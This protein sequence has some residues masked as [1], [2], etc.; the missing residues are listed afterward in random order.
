MERDRGFLIISHPATGSNRILAFAIYVVLL[1]SGL[2]TVRAQ[3]VHQGSTPLR[4][5][6]K[7]M[8]YQT[9]SSQIDYAPDS[10]K[11]PQQPWI[12]LSDREANTTYTDSAK[13][14]IQRSLKYLEQLYVVEE[15]GAYVHIVRDS[16]HVGLLLSKTYE[17]CGWIHKQNLLLWDFCI[18]DRET[19]TPKRVM[20]LNTLAHI[21]GNGTHSSDLVEFRRSPDSDTALARTTS[22]FFQ[23]FFLL[24]S[25]AG[26]ALVS[27][28]EYI[29]GRSSSVKIDTLVAGWIPWTRLVGWYNRVAVEPNWDSAACAERAR[30]KRARVFVNEQ[31]ALQ[32]KN[33]EEAP[34]EAV[35]WDDDPLERRPPGEWRRF[36]VLRASTTSPGVIEVMA[37]GS[38]STTQGIAVRGFL[39]YRVRNQKHPLFRR[40]ILLSRNELYDH[41]N[42]LQELVDA[43]AGRKSLVDAWLKL[44][45][46]SDSAGARRDL[47][48]RSLAAVNERIF[49]MSGGDS[50]SARTRLADIPDTNLTREPDLVRYLDVLSQKTLAL[51]RAADAEEGSYRYMFRSNGVAYYWIGEELLP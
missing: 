30:G 22:Q 48:D 15:K 50:F 5:L 45:R 49:G 24:K 35:W 25:E 13:T 14:E 38:T 31:A 7:P 43:R 11:V 4:I 12:V 6:E 34:D 27:T 8:K 46:G 26:W 10:V 39:T 17:D 41:V 32:Y 3:S 37:T 1:S 36:P 40:V 23:F 51:K 21:R 47:L 29:G 20:I 42:K 16:A 19:G 9:P 2:S 28:V 18:T 33:G 44:A